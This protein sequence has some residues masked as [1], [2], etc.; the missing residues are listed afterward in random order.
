MMQNHTKQPASRI[1]GANLK[2]LLKANH[3]T[4][5]KFAEEFGASPR[6]VRRWIRDFPNL[7]TLEQIAAFFGVPITEFFSQ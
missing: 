4:Q 5:E 3:L 7:D 1:V 6:T 2:R